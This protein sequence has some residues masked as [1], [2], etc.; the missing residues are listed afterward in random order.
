M[1]EYVVTYKQ[2]KAMLAQHDVQLFDVRNPEEFQ[3]GH[4][5]DSVNIPLGDL[6]K[7]LKLSPEQF[8]L[9]FKV[10]AP[11]KDDNNIVLHCQRGIRGSKALEI[12]HRLGFSR[13]RHFKG[14][15]SE[16]ALHEVK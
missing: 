13:A 8:Q 9:I 14:G 15:Y 1:D 12:A 7:S 2:L 10:E 4:I 6:E 3:A 5:P 16:W 11:G